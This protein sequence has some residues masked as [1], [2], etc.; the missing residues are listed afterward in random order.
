MENIRIVIDG[1]NLD[2][3]DDLDPD[4]IFR[5]PEVALEFIQDYFD[6]ISFIGV[7][8][9]FATP[10]FGQ[11]LKDALSY[12]KEHHVPTEVVPYVSEETIRDFSADDNGSDEQTS[13]ATSSQELG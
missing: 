11:Q 8:D 4:I 13:E 3:L 12:K 5:S 6:V 7:E 9:E 1:K 2:G 10:E